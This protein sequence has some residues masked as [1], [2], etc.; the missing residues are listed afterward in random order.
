MGVQWVVLALINMRKQGHAKLALDLFEMMHLIVG[1]PYRSASAGMVQ[2]EH[3]APGLD[4]HGATAAGRVN[5]VQIKVVRLE[6]LQGGVK[7]GSRGL[8]AHAFGWELRDEEHVGT[9]HP[10]TL[11]GRADGRLVGVQRCTRI[12]LRT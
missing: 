9:R 3:R 5:Q 7:R 8:A 2:F 1:D 11:E 10:A 12:D 6:R 4:A